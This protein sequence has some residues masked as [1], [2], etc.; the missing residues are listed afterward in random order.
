MVMFGN[1]RLT[2]PEYFMSIMALTTKKENPLHMNIPIK[3]E[4]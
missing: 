1:L 4:N 2:E 3:Q